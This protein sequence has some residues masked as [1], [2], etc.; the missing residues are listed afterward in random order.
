MG[1]KTKSKAIS[2]ALRSEIVEGKFDTTR[3]LPSEHQL[4]RRFS[5]A[6]ETV[7]AAIKIL[8]KGEIVEI[9]RG[10]G[11]FLADRGASHATG[12]FGAIV[13]DALHP[14]YFI[15]KYAWAL[16]RRPA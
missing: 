4:M 2:D 3:R 10:C 5:A 11:V 14:F 1:N 6:R 15:G 12:R 16:S 8:A 7:R 9:R 13:P